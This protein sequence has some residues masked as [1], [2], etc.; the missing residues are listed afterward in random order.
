LS[1][2]ERTRAG[3]ALLMARQTNCLVL[4]EPTNHLDMPAIEQLEQAVAG[5][6]GTLLLVSHDRRLVEAV[7]TQRRLHVAQGRVRED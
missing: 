4:D 5:Y 7:P 3:L 6:T 1:P 2:G